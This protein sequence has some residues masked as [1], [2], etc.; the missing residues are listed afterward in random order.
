MQHNEH[1]TFY[2]QIHPQPTHI[3]RIPNKSYLQRLQPIFDLINETIDVFGTTYTLSAV[4][5]SLAIDNYGIE[6]G[7]Q[8]AIS[9]SNWVMPSLG[10]GS[11]YQGYAPPSFSSFSSINIAL[12]MDVLNQLLYQVWGAGFIRQ[13]LSLSEFGVGGDELELLFPNATDARITVE[14]L[15]PPIATTNSAGVLEMQLGELYIAIHNGDYSDGDIRLELYSHIFAPLTLSASAS[16]VGAELGDP[17]SHFDVVYP[18]LGSEGTEAL[19]EALIPALLPSLTSA[20]SSIE[21]PSFEGFSIGNTSS[22][23]STSH[24]QITGTITN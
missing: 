10:L 13:E 3:A 1:L 24:I 16:S 19:L 5:S 22:T 12:S 17:T 4:P 2:A 8:T 11:L 15:L 18:E 14:P 21:I 7:L 6:L 23:T 20:L 9:S